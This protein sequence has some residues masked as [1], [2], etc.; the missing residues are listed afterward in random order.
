MDKYNQPSSDWQKETAEKKATGIK[1]TTWGLVIKVI[2]Q[3]IVTAVLARLLTPA[4]FGTMA[5]ARTF[6]QFGGYISNAGINRAIVQ[7]SE[8]TEND[9]GTAH[10]LSLFLGILGYISMIVLSPVAEG[11]YGNQQIARLICI[12]SIS[13]FFSA[14]A[15]VEK[16]KLQRNMNFYFIM[17]ADTLSY[18]LGYACTTILLAWIGFGVWSISIGT[19]M[20]SFVLWLTQRLL[21]RDRLCFKW[22]KSSAGHLMRFGGGVT[23]IS[24]FEYIGGSL[25]V[26]ISGKLWSAD[27]VGLYTKASQLV[28]LPIEYISNAL[29]APMFPALC[30]A[31]NDMKKLRDEYLSDFLL[32]CVIEFSVCIG[33]A[34]T[35]HELISI[36]LGNQW[37]S[38]VNLFITFCIAH[39]FNYSN[40]VIGIAME[41]V[42]KLKAKIVLQWTQ[43]GI[44]L[45]G[46]FLFRAWGMQG[47]AF[48]ILIA[49]VY[50]FLSIQIIMGRFLKWSISDISKLIINLFYVVLTQALFQIIAVITANIL[51][52]P[53]AISLILH[54]FCGAVALVFVCLLCPTTWIKQYV[55]LKRIVFTV[56]NKKGK[57]V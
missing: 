11:F 24:A 39:A 19:V 56:L 14:L 25:D 9:I 13:Y 41:A 31:K 51:Q 1:W 57:N 12:T 47:V 38:A 43:I 50:K 48:S 21:C 20:Q 28:T 34:F 8:V 17:C 5:L 6:L 29:T 36:V 44:L 52:V 53:L 49:Q 37:L 16:G 23:V 2:A 10:S 55:D 42:G 4:E 22:D 32:V 7:K 3:F 30:A 27:E 35:A 15:M 26:I 54:I 40:T 18:I 46:I 45:G 33:M